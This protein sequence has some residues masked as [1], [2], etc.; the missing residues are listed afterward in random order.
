MAWDKTPWAVGGGA[1]HSVEVARL[2]A[3]AATSGA[4]GIVLPADLKVRQTAVA[5]GKVQVDVG[6]AIIR[7]RHGGGGRQTYVGNRPTAEDLVDIT[8]TGSSGGRNDLVIAKIEDPQYPPT[9][10]PDNWAEAQFIH[11]RVLEG[12]PAGTKSAR[13]LNLGYPAIALA[14]IEIPPS[15]ATI[16]DAM[17]KDV[18]KVANPRKLRD[19]RTMFPPDANNNMSSVVGKWPSSSEFMV[20]VPEWATRVQ[21]VAHLSGIEYQRGTTPRTTA[22]LYTVFAGARSE[23][24]IAWEANAGRYHY[25]FA[26]THSVGAHQRGTQQQ[27]RLDARRTAGDGIYQADSQTVVIVDYEFQEVAD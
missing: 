5:S 1:L 26:G 13:D 16:T 14:R 21:I 19:V 10:P 23:N 9:Q 22:A 4:E 12:V 15:T 20:D 25:S 11:T 8:P 27:I 24:G 2:L 17:I 18:R 3:F 6:A 7:N